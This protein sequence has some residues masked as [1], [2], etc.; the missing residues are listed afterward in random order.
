MR[1]GAVPRGE[2]Q[3]PRAI[4]IECPGVCDHLADVVSLGQM[5][6]SAY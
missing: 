6:R 2:I 1:E 5:R 3:T 4:G